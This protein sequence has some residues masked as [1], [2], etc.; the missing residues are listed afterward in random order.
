MAI[1]IGYS[2]FNRKA[3]VDV[4]SLMLKYGGGGHKA[5]ETCQVSYDDADKIVG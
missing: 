2:I 4:D 1:S 3:K 5:V